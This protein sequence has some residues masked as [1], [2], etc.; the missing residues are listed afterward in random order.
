MSET[1]IATAAAN[2]DSHSE[3]IERF[4]IAYMEM[5][6]NGTI[7]CANRI[8]GR[9]FERSREEMVGK[10]PWEFMA[11]EEIE[12]SREAYFSLMRTGGDPPPVRRTVIT[13]KGEFRTY[14]MH[15]TL[16]T[17]AEGRPA[18]MRYAAV[19]ITAGEL[20]RE[21]AHRSQ[22]WL[23][24]VLESV[25]EAVLVTDALGF[26]RYAN[27]AA[28][29]LSGWTL[30]ELTGKAIEKCL[31]LLSCSS[32]TGAPLNFRMT[33]EKKWKGT[34]TVLDRDRKELRLEISTSPIIDKENGYTIGVVSVLQRVAAT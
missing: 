20:A 29:E 1:T 28:T 11:A 3:D 12:N 10:T 18:G 24:S 30:S 26:I 17:D 34:A 27:P 14:D 15:R 21:Q 16:I 5:D 31:P 2:A 32:P 6:V 7:T 9:V 23:E 8:A 19:D 33:V 25:A 22:M 13:Q 4:P